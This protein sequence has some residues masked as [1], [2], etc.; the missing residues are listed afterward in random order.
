MGG[1]AERRDILT[2]VVAC[3]VVWLLFSSAWPLLPLR[4]FVTLIHEAGHATVASLVGGDVA[5]VTINE[6]GGGLTHWS[7]SGS[8]SSLRRVLVGAAGY[9]GAA[10]AGG[11]M[12]EFASRVRRGRLGLLLLAVVVAAIGIAWV[13]WETNPT[14]AAAQLSGSSD[15]DGRF[16]TYFCVAAVVVLVLLALQ[17]SERVRRVT[18]LGIAT[19]LC[20]ASVDDMRTVLDMSSRGGHSDAAAAAEVTALSS[21]TW[22]VIWLLIGLLACGLGLWAALSDDEDARP[23]TPGAASQ[24]GEAK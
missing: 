16:T 5:S 14:G 20:L 9:V 21:W 4:W 8:M 12:M 1:Q 15:D 18:L 3:G 17:R 19:V 2:T 22:S 13:P 23:G 10:I 24:I 7:Y 6:N 11:F